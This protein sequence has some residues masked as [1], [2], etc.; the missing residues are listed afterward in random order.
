M[1]E[2]LYC[3]E[4]GVR[5]AG[6]S[7]HIFE[8]T[9]MCD[10]CFQ[11]LTTVCD[12]CSERIWRS[13]AEGDSDTT[14]CT[15]C[16]ENRY[17][18]C[19]NCGGLVHLDD[20]HYVDCSD[21]PYC[22]DCY[23]NLQNRTIKEYHYKPEP[24]FYGSGNLFMGVELEIDDGGEVESYAEEI[25]NVGNAKNAHIYCKHD[26]SLDN[27]VELVS[28][29]MTM[30]YHMQEMNWQGVLRKAVSLGYS[31]HNTSTCGLHVHCSRAAFGKDYE[32]QEPV[33]GRI[34]Y[35]VEKNWCELVKFSR[36]TSRSLNRWAARY[37]TISETAKETYEKAKSKCTGRYVAVN[38]ENYSTIEFRMFRG[39][40]RY[41]TFMAT[42]QLVHEIC[43]LAI[44]TTDYEMEQLSWSEFVS[45]IDQKE[46]PE[47]IAYLKSKRLYVN[48]N[49]TETE[50]V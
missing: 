41:Q 12:C 34:I 6:E 20:V 9:V 21:Y 32:E 16:Y 1:N 27:G 28:Q 36:R 17:V 11:R 50:E 49:E 35:F 19:G 45:G 31:S 39:T 5:L 24:I 7:V 40:L 37:A 23:D 10:H 2:E 38:L 43:T 30:E 14:L 26:G 47:L 48:E 3:Q 8:E 4:C 29:P 13:D 42:L 22:E 33:I 46:K 15:Y 18:T 25:M 44:K